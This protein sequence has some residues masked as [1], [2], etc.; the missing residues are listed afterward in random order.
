MTEKEL[1]RLEPSSLKSPQ[2]NSTGDLAR[3]WNHLSKNY[4]VGG[5][6]VDFVLDNAGLELF[7]DLALGGSLHDGRD[8]KLNASQPIL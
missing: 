5:S 1:Q 6:R 7:C 4:S 2:V 8:W 3:L